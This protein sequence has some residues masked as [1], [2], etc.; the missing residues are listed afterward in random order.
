M[1]DLI[2]VASF[3]NVPRLE[4]TTSVQGGAGG[5]S[6]VALQ[7]L[8]NRTEFLNALIS[9]SQYKGAWSSLTIYKVNQIV[10]YNGLYYYSI[11]NN[12]QSNLPTNTTFWLLFGSANPGAQGPQG[13][14][15]QVGP[16]GLQGAQGNTGANGQAGAVGLLVSTSF[17]FLNNTSP[18]AISL[19]TL[20]AF[21]N[22]TSFPA[23]LSTSSIPGGINGTIARNGS[24]NYT[25]TATVAP[26]STAAIVGGVDTVVITSGA[27]Y[28]SLPNLADA[29][30]VAKGDNLVAAKLQGTDAR[31]S[32]VAV[33][34]ALPSQ[35]IG[36]FGG[37]GQAT[38]PN[39]LA[40]PEATT[41]HQMLERAM[42]NVMDFGAKGD[43]VTDDSAAFQKALDYA[44][45]RYGGA[46]VF[47][48]SGRYRIRKTIVVHAGCYLW[49]APG[50]QGSPGS[51]SENNLYYE[52][53]GVT[54]G[55]NATAEYSSANAPIPA[56]VTNGSTTRY[57]APYGG[58][59]LVC[60]PI[61]V[62]NTQAYMIA[63]AGCGSGIQN[64]GI[65]YPNQTYNGSVYYPPTIGWWRNNGTLP[66][67]GVT[68]KDIYDCNSHTL[69]EA[70]GGINFVIDGIRSGGHGS[71]FR[72]AYNSGGS[73]EGHIRN[74]WYNCAY[75]YFA[76]DS[77]G[78]VRVRRAP[79]AGEPTDLFAIDYRGAGYLTV[80]NLNAFDC[81]GIKVASNG[82]GGKFTNISID[83]RTPLQIAPHG[84]TGQSGGDPIIY[85]IANFQASKATG[86]A[87]IDV[88]FGSLAAG[89]NSNSISFSTSQFSGGMDINGCTNINFSSVNFLRGLNV[90]SPST[91]APLIMSFQGC[92]F[93]ESLYNNNPSTTDY[94]FKFGGGRVKIALSGSTMA[95][96]LIG[97][98]DVRAPGAVGQFIVKNMDRQGTYHLSVPPQSL[99]ANTKYVVGLIPFR[100][101][102]NAFTGDALP[103]QWNLLESAFNGASY[104]SA[105][106]WELRLVKD[107]AQ[108]ATTAAI[109]VLNPNDLFNNAQYDLWN[110]T[111]A[112]RE[113]DNWGAGNQ[114]AIW[115]PDFNGT[116]LPLGQF[117][118][119]TD[120][121]A[122]D[123]Q[124]TREQFYI[125]ICLTLPVNAT[126]AANQLVGFLRYC[127]N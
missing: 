86:P 74:V 65:V 59:Y 13:V 116:G 70:G 21:P 87:I 113:S 3:D 16:T 109:A 67:A 120:Q 1:T 85:T 50:G 126:L 9:G 118:A 107:P 108:A 8:A 88:P 99:V 119:P 96:G 40:Y 73:S 26:G 22:S 64:F 98:T 103:T 2:P 79:V 104:F 71:L 10:L 82:Y 115:M 27:F 68:V 18:Q 43:N 101:M 41:V 91:E 25:F 110:A 35:N 125:Q 76:Q 28:G 112:I 7:A 66:V 102:R 32:N 19:T 95:Q 105:N 20:G 38:V 30:D 90:R 31:G 121:L 53:W 58:P 93:I 17:T 111:N 11:A 6:N 63:L 47:G 75:G 44:F 117:N 4:T 94:R 55:G 61:D 29:I 34:Q 84:T 12:N 81:S 48:P 52:H 51:P 100:V 77:S 24:G 127:M 114:Y 72:T 62:V 78:R 80:D 92:A 33:G 54:N 122:G 83:G 60:D 23:I 89:S 5:A 97:T 123:T 69:I 36:Y 14:P 37:N 124:G 15:G 49:G 46:T 106:M 56:W 39:I 45:F 57:N 42:L